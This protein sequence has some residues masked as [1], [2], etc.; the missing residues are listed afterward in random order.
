MDDSSEEKAGKGSKEN[1]HREALESWT[2]HD[3]LNTEL[4]ILLASPHQHM[5]V[6][7]TSR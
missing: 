6:C 2:P 1:L 5:L 3:P 7:F 4:L